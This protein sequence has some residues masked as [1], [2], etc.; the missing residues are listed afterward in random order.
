MIHFLNYVDMILE[1]EHE[2]G[3]GYSLGFELFVQSYSYSYSLFVG[4]KFYGISFTTHFSIK[5][6]DK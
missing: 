3:H 6:N 2:L 4:G 1:H 5:Y